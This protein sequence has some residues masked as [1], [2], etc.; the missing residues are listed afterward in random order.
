M[1]LPIRQ[2][3]RN[4]PKSRHWVPAVS[5]SISYIRDPGHSFQATSNSTRSSVVRGE[6]QISKQAHVVPGELGGLSIPNT[7]A[8]LDLA[9]SSRVVSLGL[10]S[11]SL[12]P[13]YRVVA[14]LVPFTPAICCCVTTRGRQCLARPLGF[15]GTLDN[16]FCDSS[17][18]RPMHLNLIDS[19]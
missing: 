9:T 17:G 3:R 19:V 7:T 18:G 16:G 4:L 14:L 13:S 12:C 11:N 15:Y 2:K 6:A 1:P 8:N 10:P 5:A